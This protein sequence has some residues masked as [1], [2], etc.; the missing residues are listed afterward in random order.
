MDPP[1]NISKDAVDR[2]LCK[3][4][5]A[6]AFT[7]ARLAR[8]YHATEQSDKDTLEVLVGHGLVGRVGSSDY[9]MLR[10]CMNRM[11]LVSVLDSSTVAAG[12]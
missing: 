2:V 6:Q 9:I 4:V 10:C 1:D 5:S 8:S 3:L 12:H 7:G 11:G